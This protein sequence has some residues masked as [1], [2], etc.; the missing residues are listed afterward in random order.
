MNDTNI[1]DNSDDEGHPDASGKKQ[2]PVGAQVREI[3]KKAI[4]S[5]NIVLK[6]AEGKQPQNVEVMEFDGMLDVLFMRLGIQCPS[7]KS[8]EE[9]KF[10]FCIDFKYIELVMLVKFDK[11]M[12]DLDYISIDL[13]RQ[14]T[15]HSLDEQRKMNI[16][17]LRRGRDKLIAAMEKQRGITQNQVQQNI[18]Q[19]PF[20]AE[21]QGVSQSS[22][23]EKKRKR[24]DDKK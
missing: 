10:L 7:N 13:L 15:D 16:N 6:R 22:K 14:A 3:F 4:F 19:G 20:G 2:K 23:Q 9:L 12:H 11:V 1:N 5:K 17:A 24:P 18:H 8:Q 21:Y